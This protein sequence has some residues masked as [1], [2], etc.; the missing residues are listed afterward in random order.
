MGYCVVTSGQGP[1]WVDTKTMREQELWTEHADFVNSLMYAGFIILAGPLGSGR[2]HRAL[3]IVNSDDDVAVR[4]RLE[5]DPWI[6]AGMLR[7]LTIES[8]KILVSNDKLDPVLA[9]I[10]KPVP[11]S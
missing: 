6:V 5:S 1:A 10:T 4:A 7:I 9:E 3:L 8:W 11:S 2:P